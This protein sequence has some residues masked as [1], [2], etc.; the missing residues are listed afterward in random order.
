MRPDA[1]LEADVLAATLADPEQHARNLFAWLEADDFT[2]DATRAVFEAMQSVAKR[3]GNEAIAPATVQHELR[4]LGRDERDIVNLLDPDLGLGAVG[5]FE[6]KCRMLRQI[7]QT[8]YVTGAMTDLMQNGE[9]QPQ[10]MF[11]AIED[12]R[13][14]AISLE[15]VKPGR[16]FEDLGDDFLAELEFD[17]QHEHHRVKTGLP[18]VDARLQG[19]GI[20]GGWLVVVGARTGVGKTMFAVQCTVNAAKAGHHVIYVTIEESAT[21][22]FERVAR[23]I[24]RVGRTSNDS[25]ALIN[26]ALDPAVRGLSIDVVTIN[27]LE[28]ICGYVITQVRERKGV[29]M[30]V[31]D[32]AGLVHAGHYESK[33]QEIGAITQGLKLL[34]MEL[35]VPVMLLAQVNRSPMSRSDTRPTLSDLRDSGSLEQDADV[36]IFLHHDSNDIAGSSLCRLAKN[37]YGPAGDLP[38]RFE[39]PTGRL[40]ELSLHG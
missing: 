2:N 32:Y 18:T 6:P 4:R 5:S 17:L 37:R 34:A 15:P 13:R 7:R 24:R 29:G 10:E 40:E 38:V 33:V 3:D 19:G 35:N 9:L 16:A 26:A 20:K 39:Y 8:R 36:V 12:I 14:Q 23:H 27:E 30:V 21:R 25:E 11:D 22:I 31:V 28:A 1:H